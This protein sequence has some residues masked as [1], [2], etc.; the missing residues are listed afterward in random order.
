MYKGYLLEWLIVCGPAAPTMAVYQQKVQKSS[1]CS[2]HDTR[3]LVF[4]ICQNTEET[5][6]KASV[7]MNLLVGVRANRQ[8][9]KASIF[10]DSATRNCG[11]HLR[12]IFPPQR[13]QLQG[14]NQLQIIQPRKIPHGYTHLTWAF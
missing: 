1:S 2:I 9:A 7:G 3:C 13:I 4:H 6:S 8:R 10:H 14:I 11:L 5:G 12:C